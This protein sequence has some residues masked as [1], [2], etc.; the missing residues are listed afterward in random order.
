MPTPSYRAQIN[1][2]DS[3]LDQLAAEQFE[4][5][6]RLDNYPPQLGVPEGLKARQE[7]ISEHIELLAKRRLEL[8]EAAD[9]QD[10]ILRRTR[11]YR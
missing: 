7:T 3:L 2:L 10:S 4:C 9:Y 1:L 5:Q 11:L 6:V 8:V